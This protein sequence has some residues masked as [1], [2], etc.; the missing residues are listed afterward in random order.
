MISNDESITHNIKQSQ[1]NN[2]TNL[3]L[4]GYVTDLKKIKNKGN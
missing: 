4:K 3:D 2:I 1:I